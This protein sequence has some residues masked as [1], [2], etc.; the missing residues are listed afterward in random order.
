[1][2]IKKTKF[3]VFAYGLS[4]IIVT[5]LLGVNDSRYAAQLSNGWYILFSLCLLGLWWFVG[6]KKKKF[7]LIFVAVIVLLSLTYCLRL[8]PYT[9]KEAVGALQIHYKQEV[10]S[11]SLDTQYQSLA[12]HIEDGKV[13]Y[14]CYIVKSDDG[15]FYFDQYT[16]AYGKITTEPQK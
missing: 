1:M 11:T 15:Y 6:R 4:V 5:I 14:Y 16:G 3:I 9:Y 8:P 13:K 12:P 10:F 2:D 7:I